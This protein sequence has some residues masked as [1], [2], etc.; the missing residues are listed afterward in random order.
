MATAGAGDV[1]AGLLAGLIASLKDYSEMAVLDA[2]IAGVYLHG[3]A[4]D[5]A[6]AALGER[7]MLASDIRHYLSDA[8]LQIGG[9]SEKETQSGILTI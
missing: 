2:V 5:M 6:A 7:Y 1:L 9:K 3:L 8:F 4:G